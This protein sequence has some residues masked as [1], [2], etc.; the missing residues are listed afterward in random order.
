MTRD[1]L[2]KMISLGE[3]QTAEFKRAAS[4]DFSREMVAFANGIGGMIFIGVDDHGV[5]VGVTHPNRVKGQIQHTARQIDPPLRIS[6]EVVDSVVVVTVSRSD[7]RPHSS[8]GRFYIREGATCQHMTRS[9]VREYFLREGTFLFDTMVNPEF[10]VSKDLAR[11]SYQTFAKSAG[12]PRKLE[13]HDALRNLRMLTDKGMTNAG[14]L[15]LGRHGSRYLISATVMCALF[16]GT[17]KTKILDQKL[18]D[19]DIVTNYRNALLYLQS[20]LNTEYVITSVRTNVLELPEEALREAV[21]NAIAHRDY[22]SPAN[23]QIYIFYDRVEIHNPGGLVPGLT[24]SDLGK[25]SIPRNP[26][27]FGLLYR[28]D[29]VEH[30]GSGLRRI[31]DVIKSAGHTAPAIEADESWYVITFFR[32]STEEKAGDAME[33][34]VEKPVEKI[35]DLIRK[36]NT[37]TSA[38]IVRRTG[39]TRRGVE[40]QITRMK[41]SGHLKRIGPDKGGRWEV[42]DF[43]GK[44]ARQKTGGVTEI[45][46]EKNEEKTVEKN[47]E[48]TVENRSA[49]IL[50]IIRLDNTVTSAAIVRRTGLTRRGVEWQIARMKQSGRL[51]RIGPDKGG[52]WEVIDG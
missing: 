45:A 26:L 49:E 31:R 39:L 52:H 13:M 38:E 47:E 37:I 44:T 33:K 24:I 16:Q 35:L 46:V 34:S 48:K 1:E 2:H 11:K 42:L 21:I 14:A 6:I 41:Q 22:R 5:I 18:F 8:A 3:G 43:L 19:D 36:D 7:D 51:K 25:R 27:L 10:D 28:I 9:Q 29:L 12:V 4:E 32:K 30:I 15:L 17:T 23:I 50:G 20:H 40:W